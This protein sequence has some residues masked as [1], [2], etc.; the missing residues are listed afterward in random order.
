MAGLVDG[1]HGR[2]QTIRCVVLLISLTFKPQFES[3]ILI[4]ETGH[5]I[6]TGAYERA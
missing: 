4:T 1:H 6:L 5:E 3:T 2:R